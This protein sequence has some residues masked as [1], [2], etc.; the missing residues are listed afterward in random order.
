MQWS[1][2][3]LAI[4]DWVTTGSGSAIVDAVA[5]SGKTTTIVE[6]AKRIPWDAS[7]IFCAFNKSIADQLKSRLPSNVPALTLNALGNR[8]W[9]AYTE[10][11]TTVDTYKVSDIVRKMADDTNKD[12]RSGVVRLVALAKAVGLVPSLALSSFPDLHGLVPDSEDAWV[13]L[14]ETYDIDF[15]YGDRL[16]SAIDL[17]RHVLTQS[18]QTGAEVIDF[19]DQ[20]YLP[21]IF[22]AT[23]P[24]YDFVF[25]DEA[26]DVN[27]IQ[28]E[29]ISRSLA[30]GGRLIAVGDD[31]QSIY[32]FR[33]AGSS[34]D[35]FVRQF[36]C[37][38]LPLS[39]T[40]RCA[41]S[42]TRK[43]QEYVPHIQHREDAPE[44][45]VKLLHHDW[46]PSTFQ[47]PDLILCRNNAPLVRAAFQ[48]IRAKVPCHVL[49]RDIG[50][51]LV[52][53]V[54]KMRALSIRDLR[55]K[56]DRH[57]ESETRKAVAAGRPQQVSALH[58]K[59]STLRVFME[60]GGDTANVTDLTDRISELFE[61]DQPNGTLTLATVHKSKGLEFGR[62]F[63]LDKELIGKYAVTP[64]QIQQEKNVK[65]VATTRA[66]TELYYISSGE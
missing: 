9:K 1:P 63:L 23:F 60:E 26:Q 32:F 15:G 31:N 35:G 59:V 13:E 61:T 42:I 56:L 37:V 43:A 41:R 45:I 44:G 21:V 20:L 57:L 40:Y 39:T 30:T 17:A 62:V 22:G 50:K 5:G 51:G 49:G 14:V 8:A 58:D 54:H 24:Q 6:A 19:N 11:W 47:R 12:F 36:N 3:Q 2:Q 27:A 66:K 64:D 4:F 25:V 34:M 52:A 7:A 38:R 53:L 10:K 28:F 65:Y 29:M 18:I 48:C 33:G 16:T 55:D 46:S